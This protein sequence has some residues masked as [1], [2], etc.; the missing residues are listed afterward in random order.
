MPKASASS[1]ANLAT[2]FSCIFRLSRQAAF[3]ACKKAKRSHLTSP[4]GPKAS[5]QKT[6][7]LSNRDLPGAESRCRAGCFEEGSSLEVL[8]RSLVTTSKQAQTLERG[9]SRSA[10]RIRHDGQFEY[11]DV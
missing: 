1:A 2:T 8:G 10:T 4:R 5:R 6:S 3:A 11:G 7:D 9:T